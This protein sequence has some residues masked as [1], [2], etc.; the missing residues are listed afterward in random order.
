VL[1]IPGTSSV[2]HL[3]ENISAASLEI[4]LEILDKLN[5]MV[6]DSG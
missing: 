4:P 3:R 5:A 2:G 1:L 6:A